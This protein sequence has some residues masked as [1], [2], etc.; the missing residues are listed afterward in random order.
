M[1][2]VISDGQDSAVVEY[3]QQDYHNRR[4]RV[5]LEEQDSQGQESQQSNCLRNSIDGIV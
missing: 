2:I 4:Y 3:R 1:D 5:E